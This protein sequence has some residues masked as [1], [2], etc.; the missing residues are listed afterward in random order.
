MRILSNNPELLEKI[1]KELKLARIKVRKETKTVDGAMADEVITL[2]E[3][4]DFIQ[5]HHQEIKYYIKS[6]FELGQYLKSEIK[7][8][9]KDGTMISYEEYETMSED[10]LSKV[11]SK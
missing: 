1:H 4:Y 11:F 9:L 8:E 5:N 2:L 10:E 3:L 6:V 7:V